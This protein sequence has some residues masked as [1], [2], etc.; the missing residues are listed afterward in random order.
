MRAEASQLSREKPQDRAEVVA[1]WAKLEVLSPLEGTIIE[2]NVALGDLVDTNIDLFKIADLSR[3]RVVA[4]AYEEDLPALDSL[5]NDHRE[6]TVAIGTGE[7][8]ATRKGQFDQVGCII[9]PNQHTALVMGWVDNR[10]GRLRVGQFVTVR[11]EVP[12][13]KSEVVV[14]AT[15]LCEEAGRTTIFLRLA[16]THE[17][18]R[19]EVAVSRRCG[20][21]VFLRN[22]ITTEERQ[23]GLEP[24][25]PG[26]LV[27]ISRIAQLTASLDELKSASKSADGKSAAEK[28]EPDK[29]GA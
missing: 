8:A 19:R 4:H 24:L 5:K 21:K 2:R 23:R 15:A 28:P 6:W 12:P 7:D 25:A 20:N 11:L 18:V 3:L 9:D 13:P 29:P 1:Q 26:Q 14:P 27:V 16:D 17:Y 10:D 22:K